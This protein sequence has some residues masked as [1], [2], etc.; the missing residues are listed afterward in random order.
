MMV[1]F[2]FPVL[3]WLIVPN[4]CHGITQHCESNSGRCFWISDAAAG[5]WDEGRTACQS[6]GG[7]LAVMETEELHDYVKNTIRYKEICNE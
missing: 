7:D 4:F 1:N 2:A 3:F 6:E 5:T